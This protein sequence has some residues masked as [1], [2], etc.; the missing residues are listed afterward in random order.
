MVVL[1]RPTD[2]GW[3]IIPLYDVKVEVL[4]AISAAAI[5]RLNFL[6]DTINS[7]G[8]LEKFLHNFFENLS[9]ED[10]NYGSFQKGGATAHTA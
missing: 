10:R 6:S 7:K 2:P 3:Q 9:Y 1:K 4:C 5:N 8:T